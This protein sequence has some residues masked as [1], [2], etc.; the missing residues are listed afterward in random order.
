[1][2]SSS[3][4]VITEI[5]DDADDVADLNFVGRKFFPDF[6]VEIFGTD[7]KYVSGLGNGIDFPI[8]LK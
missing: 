2:S 5:V 4:S 6:L 7:G 1:M 3:L 8:T